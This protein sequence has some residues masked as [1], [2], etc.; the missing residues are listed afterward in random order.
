[1]S[2]DRQSHAPEWQKAFDAVES[3]VGGRI[4]GGGRQARWRPVFFLEV[5]R[6]DGEILPICFRG[7]RSEV[8][9]DGPIRR[10]YECFK[11]LEGNGILVPE[12]HG[13]CE[14]PPG[15]VMQTSPGRHDLA[16]AESPEEFESVRDDFIR[17]LADIHRLPTRDFEGFGL[18]KS[19]DARIL[20]LGDSLSSIKRFRKGKSRPEPAL[21]F[22]IDWTERNIPRDRSECCFVTGDSGQFIFEKGRVTAMLDM[23]L[24]YLGDPLA[25]LG[26]LFCRD[27][28][29]TMGDLSVAIDRYEAAIGHA[30]DRR[31]VLYHAIRFS[32]TTPLGTAL[33]VAQPPLSAEYVQYLTWYLVYTRCP[34]ELI[35]HLEGI[36]IPEPDLPEATLSPYAVPHDAL[37]A[38]FLAFET[39]DEFQAYEAD[40]LR[41]L[42]L[43]LRQGDR[44]GRDLLERDLDE[45]E[46]L[47]GRRPT[48]W[49]DRDA[50]LEECVR[51]SAG[52]RNAD[53]VRYFVRR[54]KREEALLAPAMRDLIGV[55]MQTLPIG[56]G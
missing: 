24:A 12:I 44:F 47:L 33:A 34:L 23:E 51:D 9:D 14:S 2:F 17:I 18:E 38:R 40:G 13:F 35:A 54:F 46:S 27:L 10:E 1:M 22:L 39:H 41:R 6:P 25:D 36:E 52:T 43:Y 50:A 29:E 20:A 32:M 21:E 4:V 53:L 28:S 30:V 37:Q 7:G 8:A 3:L 56:A 49:Q 45:V 42:A 31:T 19:T 5:E 15:I 48:S 16:T 11:A 55:R 26:G